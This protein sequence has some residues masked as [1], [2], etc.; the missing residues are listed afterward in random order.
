MEMYSIDSH[1]YLKYLLKFAE[2]M[3][4]MRGLAAELRGARLW[5]KVATVPTVSLFGS[6]SYTWSMSNM[7]YGDQHR[8]NTK[9]KNLNKPPNIAS[10]T[11]PFF[12]LVRIILSVRKIFAMLYS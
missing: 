3:K 10:T 9:D 6:S 5:M 12:T 4:Y 8:I 11:F 2:N 1:A 7:M